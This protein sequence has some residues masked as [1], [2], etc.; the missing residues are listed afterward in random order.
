MAAAPSLAPSGEEV[1]SIHTTASAPAILSSV[2]ANQP[3]GALKSS[4]WPHP[5]IF[6]NWLVFN[7]VPT[8]VEMHYTF[9]FRMSEMCKSYRDD[10]TPNQLELTQRIH[11]V[12]KFVNMIRCRTATDAQAARRIYEERKLQGISSIWSSNFIEYSGLSL[13]ITQRLCEEMFERE[14]VVREDLDVIDE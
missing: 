2:T 10:G 6:T 7:F 14:K 12:G 8:V 13:Q 4:P 9:E 1:E 3:V 5:T 11:N